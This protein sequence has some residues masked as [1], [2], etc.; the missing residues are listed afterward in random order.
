MR[1][2]QHL[3]ELLDIDEDGAFGFEAYRLMVKY[4]DQQVGTWWCR[5]V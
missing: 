3:R 4:N 2:W 5:D 1:R